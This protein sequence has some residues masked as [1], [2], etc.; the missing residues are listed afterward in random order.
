[1]RLCGV[2]IGILVLAL[3]VGGLAQQGPPPP[4]V[5]PSPP[6]GAR[7]GPPPGQGRGGPGRGGLGLGGPGRGGLDGLG[8]LR[9][10]DGNP[11]TVEKVALGRQLFFDKNLSADHSVSCATCHDPAAAFTDGRALAR[12]IH[13]ADGTR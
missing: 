10:P 12:G 9:V 4:G 13:G 6:N 7:Q 2:F 11:M 3:G 5:P 1:M 8:A